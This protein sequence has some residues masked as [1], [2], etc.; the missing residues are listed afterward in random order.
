[1]RYKLYKLIDGEWR[2]YGTW[3][4]IIGLIA[5]ANALGLDGYHTKVEVVG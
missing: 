1:M 5:A 3:K 2:Y 4:D